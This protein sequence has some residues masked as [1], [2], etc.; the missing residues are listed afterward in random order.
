MS[1]SLGLEDDKMVD[2]V[3]LK[4]D[5]DQTHDFAEVNDHIFPVYHMNKNNFAFKIA[6]CI[7]F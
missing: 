3:N 4:F 5:K 6:K 7:D 2:V 1:K